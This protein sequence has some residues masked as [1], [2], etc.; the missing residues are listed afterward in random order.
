M[1]VIP[2][3]VAVASSESKVVPTNVDPME[4]DMAA[5]KGGAT[6]T[7]TGGGGGGGGG[8]APHT[9]RPRK[10]R[11]TYMIGAVA[12]GT[13]AG[14]GAAAA[15]FAPDALSAAGMGTMDFLE[16]AGQFVE[17]AIP[18]YVCVFV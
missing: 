16:G 6:A 13:A 7:A 2:V 3:A 14:I 10:K 12:L 17:A 1:C 18:R 11:P 4:A 15:L 5:F 9:N 8:A